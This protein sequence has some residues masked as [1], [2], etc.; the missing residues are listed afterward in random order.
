MY[1]KT[2]IAAAVLALTAA[3]AHAQVNATSPGPAPGMHKSPP[4]AV[5][6]AAAAPIAA[7]VAT[8]VTASAAAPVS[9]P[10]EGASQAVNPFSGKPLSLETRQRALEVS[11]METSLLE[12]RLK[13][14]ALTEDL[15]VLPL[16][17][18]VET[19]Q[20]TTARMKEE[21]AQ[22]EV[23]L[24]PKLAA[25]QAANSP[26]GANPMPMPAE[27]KAKAKV[28][29]VQKA[30][31][32]IPEASKPVAAPV[33]APHVE[34]NTVMSFGGVRSAVLDIDGNILTVKHG[35]NTPM[36]AVDIVDD[37]SVRVGGR[38]YKVH[39][40]TLARVVISDPKPV[41]PKAPVLAPLPPAATSAQAAAPMA[42]FPG[43]AGQMP[44]GRNG[45]PSLPPL[46]LPKGVTLLPAT[47]N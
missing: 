26:K 44:V 15:T 25:L 2:F 4:A 34:V 23:A 19:A 9:A 14:A 46:Q 17:K 38:A 10:A 32:S 16:K 36:G 7:P 1:K 37:Q 13:Q 21:Y 35:D 45:Q 22:K 11:K 27:A 39:G 43:P 8:P 47:A 3:A 31:V 18:Q 12:E 6:Q 20:A 5:K 24:A 29:P 40:A 33:Q 30:K 41:D 42:T 28:R